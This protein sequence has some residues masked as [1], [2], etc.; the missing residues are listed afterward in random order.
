[1]PGGWLLKQQHF[2]LAAKQAR[3][4][5]SWVVGNFTAAAAAAA[6][7]QGAAATKKRCMLDTLVQ[8]RV[9]HLAID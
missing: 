2:N 5:F 4:C 8:V 7:P 9:L 6:P 1:M 3:G